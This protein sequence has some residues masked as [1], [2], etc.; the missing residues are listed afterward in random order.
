MDKI[1]KGQGGDGSEDDSWLG[2][3]YQQFK[4]LMKDEDG[5][6]DGQNSQQNYGADGLEP[7]IFDNT[8][9]LADDFNIMENNGMLYV[10]NIVI[11]IFCRNYFY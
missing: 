3:I 9:G 10:A 1:A 5:T 6:L 4:H 8:W 2:Q 11:C 7:P